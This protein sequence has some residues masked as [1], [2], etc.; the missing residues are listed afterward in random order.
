MKLLALFLEG[1]TGGKLR[2]RPTSV[3]KRGKQ[4]RRTAA[5]VLLRRLGAELCGHSLVIS[6]GL[7]TRRSNMETSNGEGD[8]ISSAIPPWATAPPVR[9]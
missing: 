3:A 8:Y 1:L 5:K 9:T 7:L 6:R 4:K 2:Y